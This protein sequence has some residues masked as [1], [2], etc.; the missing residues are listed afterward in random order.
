MISCPSLAVVK[1]A[2]RTPLFYHCVSRRVMRSF[3]C[4]VDSYSGKIYE[5]RRGW[6]GQLFLYLP[7]VFSI[8]ICAYVVMSD[9]VHVVLS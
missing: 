4:G 9:Q 6:V 2:Y 7:L 3:L 1:L 5:Y 8:D